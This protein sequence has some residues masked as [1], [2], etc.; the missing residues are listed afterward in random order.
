VKPADVVMTIALLLAAIVAHMGHNLLHFNPVMQ[1]TAVLG[2][3]GGLLAWT[4]L[5]DVD[6]IRR[7]LDNGLDQK[8]K[9]YMSIHNGHLINTPTGAFLKS[10]KASFPPL[11]YFDIACYVSL[12]AE[13]SVAAKV[14][15]LMREYGLLTPLGDNVRR[16]VMAKYKELRQMEKNMGS[17]AMMTIAPI[18]KMTPADENAFNNFINECK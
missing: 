1:F 8:M 17:S 2:V 6:M 4:Y 13:L 12:H 5:Y 10:V 16:E 11:M 3:M 9:L 18:V 15:F 7:W 14:R